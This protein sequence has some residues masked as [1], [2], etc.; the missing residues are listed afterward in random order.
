MS[1][2]DDECCRYTVGK[3]VR[4]WYY[5]N[6]AYNWKIY[7]IKKISKKKYSAQAGGKIAKY[8]LFVKIYY[9]KPVYKTV[10]YREKV[11]VY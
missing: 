2:G 6:N 5:N 9:K 3:V 7:K 4:A 1:Y 11:P 10:T 8:K